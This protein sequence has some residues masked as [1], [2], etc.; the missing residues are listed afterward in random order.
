M[1]G[2]QS[3]GKIAWMFRLSGCVLYDLQWEITRTF[4]KINPSDAYA[5]ATSFSLL[6]W[7]HFNSSTTYS[8]KQNWIYKDDFHLQWFQSLFRC[9]IELL[10]F[11]IGFNITALYMAMLHI[12]R[13]QWFQSLC[14]CRI[15]ALN[16]SMGYSSLY[17]L[18][19][20][21]IDLSITD[22]SI[23]VFKIIYFQPCSQKCII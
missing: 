21:K 22:L 2:Y 6:S 5:Y 20:T 7:T 13:S 16:F 11:S 14:R 1:I 4:F 10:N 8:R 17:G 9:R 15:A 23:T 19:Y 3:H 18:C 12:N